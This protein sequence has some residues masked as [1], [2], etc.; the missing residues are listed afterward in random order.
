MPFKPSSS[1]LCNAFTALVGILFLAV[2]AA[3]QSSCCEVD[4]LSSM[5][6]KCGNSVYVCPGVER[7]CGVQGGNN[8]MYLS[9][10]AKQCED[11]QSV[12]IGSKCEALP[13]HGVGKPKSQT[14]GIRDR[15]DSGIG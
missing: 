1:T 9:I 3:D 15:P 6:F 13:Q 14:T 2:A 7:I 8:S 5:T 10:T 11:M 12:E 4:D